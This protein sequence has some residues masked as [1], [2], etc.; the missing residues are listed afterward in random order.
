M[1]NERDFGADVRLDVNGSNARSNLLPNEADR[2]LTGAIHELVSQLRETNIQMMVLADQ[3]AKCLAHISILID[4]VLSDT[5]ESDT[6]AVT[7]LDG[8]PIL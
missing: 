5:D 6:E 4:I 7:Y 1:S 2:S 3:T 8:S